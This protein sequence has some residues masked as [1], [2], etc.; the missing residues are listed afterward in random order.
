MKILGSGVTEE[1]RSGDLAHISDFDGNANSKGSNK[2]D[3]LVLR[4]TTV[5]GNVLAFCINCKR[6][7]IIFQHEE[8]L[9]H[10]LNIIVL[11]SGDRLFH[12]CPIILRFPRARRTRYIA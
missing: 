4:G 11:E 5:A 3:Q 2:H 6:T 7:Q 9:N 8:P 10:H 1:L 12:V